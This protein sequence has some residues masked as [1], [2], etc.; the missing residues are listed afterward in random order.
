MRHA[1]R[2]EGS[3]ERNFGKPNDDPDTY[4]GE[5]GKR[6]K[7]QPWPDDVDG[8]RV[9]FME[10]EGRRFFA[11]T[12]GQAEDEIRLENPLRLDPDRHFGGK[13]FAAEPVKIGDQPAGVLLGD[14]I[15]ANPEQREPLTRVRERIR[16]ML[17]A[18][19]R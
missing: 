4:E 16:D 19:S 12:V 18:T 17:K 13:R 14:I 6:H 7:A 5:D 9:G 3:Y 8:L 10:Q 11:V 15:A 1:I 2:Y